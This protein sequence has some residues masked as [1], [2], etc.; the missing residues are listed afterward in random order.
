MSA[1]RHI[2][3]QEMFAPGF[4]QAPG[5]SGPQ[6]PT[7]ARMGKYDIDAEIGHS[8]PVAVFRG[9]DREIGRPVTL[10][11]LASVTDKPVA[12]RFRREVAKAGNLR[13]GSMI[14]I[15]ELGDHG[16]LPFAAMQ[17]LGDDDV[18][19]A[20]NSHKSFSLLQKML[21]MWRAAEGIRAAHGGG[22]PFVGIQPSG[23][24]LAGDGSVTIQDFGIVRQTGVGQDDAVLYAAPEELTADFPPD[25]L[26]DIFAFGVVYYEL[27][28]GIHPFLDHG[29]VPL[30]Q[31]APECPK[32]LEELVHRA[33]DKDRAQRHQSLDEVQCDAEPILRELKRARAAALS[34]NASR[35]MAA[36]ELDD[37]QRGVRVALDLDPGN[38]KALKLSRVLHGLIQRRNVRSRQ[39]ILLREADEEAAARHFDRA[40]EILSAAVRLDG[41][42]VAAKSR[43][44]QVREQFEQSQ[45]CAQLVAEARELLDQQDLREARRKVSEALE[46]DPQSADAAELLRLIGETIERQEKQARVEQELAKAKSLL[47]LESFTAA[48]SILAALRAECPDSPL[49]ENLLADARAQKEEAERQARI[50]A[51]L[52]KAR[53][54]LAQQ[55][56]ADAVAKL[57][58]ASAE[59]PEDAKLAALLVEAR[60]AEER[61]RNI[62]EALARCEQFRLDAQFEQALELLDAVL[63]TYAPEPAVLSVRCEVEQQWRDYK[64]AA[65]IRPV[66]DE[67]DWLLEQD[68]PD[69]AAHFLREKCAGFSDQPTLVSRLTAI[70]AMLPGWE[71]RRFIQDS[72]AQ[73]AFLEQHQQWPVAVT[74]LEEAIKTCPDS[75]ELVEAAERLRGLLHEQE[76]GKRLA[77]RLELIEQKISAHAWSQALALIEAA[78]TEFP[79]EPKLQSLLE[80]V[81]SGLRRSQCE[82]IIAEVRQCLADGETSQAEEILRH[83]LESLNG[84]PELQALREELEAD[85]KHRDEWRRA[86]V[87][88]SRRQFE[89]A[90]A[91]LVPLAAQN[92]PDAQVLLDTCREARATSQELHFYNRGREKALKLIEQKQ[93]GQA[94]DLLHNLLSLF[95]GD[96]ILER[97]LQ[98][99]RVAGDNDRPENIAAAPEADV[100]PELTTGIQGEPSPVPASL[101]MMVTESGRGL[102]SRLTAPIAA[103]FL[104]VSGGAA[105][106]TTSRKPASEQKTPSLPA[107]ALAAADRPAPSSSEPQNARQELAVTSESPVGGNFDVAPKLIDGPPFVTP[108]VA[109]QRGIYGA[110]KLVA[111]VDKSG[112]ITNVTILS[113]HPLLASAATT[114]VMKR[115]YRPAV[116]DGEPLESKVRIQVKFRS[117]QK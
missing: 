45:Q 85:K 44:E 81:Q 86:Q 47:L 91:I 56:F 60:E 53:S 41:S 12:E 105:V 75:A 15:Y 67:V 59:F 80:D 55:R 113:G 16:A 32:A 37:A 40:V 115:R 82:N 51:Q 48:I 79:D 77:R 38:R 31:L 23:I 69:L 50:Q 93:F 11:V 89:E 103:V 58:A 106:W 25:S 116:L 35:L 63:A 74:L 39:E 6:R 13:H 112:T 28:T 36:H 1:A 46:R 64:T 83:G 70:E 33:L 27:L 101:S 42:N 95:P 104:L 111:T 30:R 76:R 107:S 21:I 108:P 110:V 19:Q 98:S 29:P 73:T 7:L 109:R 92:C 102:A 8:F 72:L 87:L 24:A 34:A 100:Q 90:E 2:R 94:A 9:F 96:A 117:G 78:Q 62:A 114:A 61:A 84:E 57:E 26:C 88:F 52:S 66:L 71:K 17:H 65:L 20:I 68:R 5:L 97:D 10:K 54:L 99:T 4:G 18:R 14:T 22:F 49:I 43:L 3:T